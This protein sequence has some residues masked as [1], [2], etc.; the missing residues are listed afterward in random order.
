MFDASRC[1]LL[2]ITRR[3]YIWLKS[4]ISFLQFNSSNGGFVHRANLELPRSSTRLYF[5]WKWH[6]CHQSRPLVSLNWSSR[7]SNY[8]SLSLTTKNCAKTYFN[9]VVEAINA[10]LTWN[11]FFSS[12]YC[13]NVRRVPIG[14]FYV[15]VSHISVYSN[16]KCVFFSLGAISQRALIAIPTVVVGGSGLNEHVWLHVA[17]KEGWRWLIKRTRASI[18]YRGHLPLC[19]H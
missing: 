4:V 10:L 1:E 16:E 11:P 19:Q 6:P 2:L 9:K 5:H 3:T 7:T 17:V 8:L 12:I 13:P 18:Q 14:V 15:C